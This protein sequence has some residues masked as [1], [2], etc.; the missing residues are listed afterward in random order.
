ML[1]ILSLDNHIYVSEGLLGV[2]LLSLDG[3]KLGDHVIDSAFNFSPGALV[4]LHKITLFDTDTLANV[5]MSNTNLTDVTLSNTYML[6][7]VIW[8]G[9]N[10]ADVTLF[11]TDLAYVSPF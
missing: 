10:L 6:A 9:T 3:D 2:V 8:S 11:D 4:L 1:V 5:T 7:D